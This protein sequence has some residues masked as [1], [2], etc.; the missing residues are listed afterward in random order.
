[1]LISILAPSFLP[2]L[3]IL[4]PSLYVDLKLRML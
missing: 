2:A 1:M 4:L 3:V